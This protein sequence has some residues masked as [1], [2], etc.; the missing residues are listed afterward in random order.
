MSTYRVYD[1]Q[2]TKARVSIPRNRRAEHIAILG[3][4]GTGKSSLL[5]FFLKQDI[6]AGRGFRMLRPSRGSDAIR[7]GGSGSAGK[8]R[9]QGIG[10]QHPVHL[11]STIACSACAHKPLLESC[12]WRIVT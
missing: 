9:R 10:T 1:G 7:A 8:T 4:T 12:G 6:Q 11:E 5:R 3:K 2:P